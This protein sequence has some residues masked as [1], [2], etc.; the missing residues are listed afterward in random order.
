[1]SAKSSPIKKW[2]SSIFKRIENMKFKEKVAQSA[3]IPL[4]AIST[5]SKKDNPILKDNLANSVF[6]KINAE[7]DYDFSPIAHNLGEYGQ[8]IYPAR[9][10]QFQRI[11]NQFLE[12]NSAAIIVNLGAGLDTTF[13]R[14]DNGRIFWIDIDFPEIISLRE[15][16]IP[17]DNRVKTIAQSILDYSWMDNNWLK[18]AQSNNQNPIPIL[19]FAGGLFMYLSKNEI[20]S[21]FTEISTRFSKLHLIF[22]VVSE[23]AL[24]Y[25]QEVLQ[26]SIISDVPMK[27]GLKSKNQ[28]QQWFPQIEI[29]E[30]AHIF[31]SI[32]SGSDWKKETKE[33]IKRNE[34]VKSSALL[35]LIFN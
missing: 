25:T 14:V 1:M 12:K 28:I 9:A 24:K 29:K 35:Y 23:E 6:K 20:K 33:N 8:L 3:F 19:F 15:K 34:Q 22:D 31:K 17:K 26:K 2:S 21:L 30:Y 11:I 16:Y 4:W 27:W 5:E 32:Q 13:F 18:P 7:Y 10:F